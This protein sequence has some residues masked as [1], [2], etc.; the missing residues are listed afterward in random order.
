[1]RKLQIRPEN[2][3]GLMAYYAITEPVCISVEIGHFRR[4]R[5]GLGG[6]GLC[7]EGE[8]KIVF[9]SFTMRHAKLSS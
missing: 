1:M 2:P 6:G 5:G 4:A 9:S 7:A 8:E 3:P